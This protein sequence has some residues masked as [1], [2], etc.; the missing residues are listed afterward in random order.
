MAYGK[1]SRQE[2]KLRESGKPAHATITEAKKGHFAIS[3]GGDAAQQVASAHVNW[4]VKLRVTPEGEEPFEVEVKEGYG[5]MGMGP[6]IGSTVPVLYDPSDHSKVVID[7]DQGAQIENKIEQ[8]VAGMSPERKARMER[9]TGLT[10]GDG[11]K[12]AIA[13]PK[14]FQDQMWA[15][16]EELKA[17]AAQGINPATGGVMN[18]PV[19]GSNPLAN[20]QAAFGAP[21][22]PAAPDPA[23]QI[24]KLAD[25]RD[26][27][28][29]TNEEFEAEKKKILGT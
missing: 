17:Q 10:A 28:A 26:R 23:D 8:T 15:R 13:D 24:A 3:S 1:E 25:L 11:M 5:E 27:G 19:S 21:A 16:A 18:Q 4:K 7:H 6:Q 14:A 29:L 9:L 20:F 2:K 22:A 12:A